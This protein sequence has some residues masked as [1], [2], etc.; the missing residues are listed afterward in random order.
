[1]IVR[2]HRQNAAKTVLSWGIYFDERK[3][4]MKIHSVG[5]PKAQRPGAFLVSFSH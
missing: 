1:V 2:I 3:A 4:S 5:D